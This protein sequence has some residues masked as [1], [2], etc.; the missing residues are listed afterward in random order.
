MWACTSSLQP[1]SELKTRTHVD[2]LYE[3]FW[4]H[5]FQALITEQMYLQGALGRDIRFIVFAFNQSNSSNMVG[6]LIRKLYIV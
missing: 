1:T 5:E 6:N 2:C 4:K 3:I